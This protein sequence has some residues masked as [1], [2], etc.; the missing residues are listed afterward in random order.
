[1][2]ILLQY[3]EYGTA[4]GI[5]TT[6]GPLSQ[7]L[8]NA[9][10]FALAEKKLS[11]KFTEKL[12][13]HY[14]YVFAGDGCLMEGLSHEACSLAGHLKL[15]KLIMF[16]DDN[17]ISIDGSTKLSTSD[18]IKKRFESYNW[19]YIKIDGHNFEEIDNAIIEAK[20]SLKP[21]IIAC[22]TTIGF[23][24]PNKS[25]KASSHGS[26]LGEEE[27][28]LVRE[29]LKWN[30]QAFEIP[31][32]LL[33]S[34]RSFYNKNIKIKNDWVELNNLVIQSDDYK[35]YFL[36]NSN[37]ELSKKIIEFKKYHFVEKTSCATRKASELSLDLISKFLPNLIG[38]SADLTGSNNTKTNEMKIIK[39]EDFHGSYIH[40]GIREHGMAGIMNGIALHGGLKTYGGTFLVFSD[41]CRPL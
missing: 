2:V 23:G 41:Y 24:S 18:D 40:Y 3:P 4:P 35:N 1:M 16:F 6:T 31:D 5:E 15:N 9:V 19:N 30:H 25:G 21:N 12:I 36:N 20:K 38:G 28:K 26:P 7:G 8:S 22:K 34:W 32:N 37:V 27:I 11:A 10:G 17:A 29:K 33:N 14:T 39:A 13:N